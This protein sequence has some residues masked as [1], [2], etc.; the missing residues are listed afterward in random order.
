LFEHVEHPL[1]CADGFV[2]ALARTLAWSRSGTYTYMFEELSCTIT[3]IHM[4]RGS[5]DILN[6][7][8]TSGNITVQGLITNGL[9]SS[10]KTL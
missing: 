3:D 5:D 4:E 8:F 7:S 2:D 9:V 10:I 6:F 1:L